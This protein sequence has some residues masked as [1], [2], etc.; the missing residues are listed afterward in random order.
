[1]AVL[2]NP[3]SPQHEAVSLAD[4]AASVRDWLLDQAP[5]IEAEKR[6]PD[7]VVQRLAS[8]DLFRMTQPS[9]F[10]GLGCSPRQAWEA[11]FQVAQGCGSCAWIIA[12]NAANVLMI[13][14]FSELAQQEV[15][16]SGRPAIISLLTG[17]VGIGVTADRVPGG[18]SLSGRWRYASGID[19]ASWAGLLVQLPAENGEPPE[20]CVMLVPKDS[21]SIDHSTW[22]VIGMRGTGSKDIYLK[23]TFVPE[24]RWLGW[25]QLQAGQK[26]PTCPNDETIYDYPLNSVFAMSILAPTL[27]VASAVAEEFRSV[28]KTRVSGVTQQRQ[29]DD[30][31]A[32]IAV[33]QGEATMAILRQTLLDD[34]DLVLDIIRSGRS[35]NPEERAAIRMRIAVSS[36]LAMDAAQ[37]MFSAMGGSLLPCNTRAE[38]LFRDFHAMSSHLLLQP[39]IIGEAYGRLLLGLEL[40]PGARL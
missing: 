36:R 19:I 26:H 23:P 11:V 20:S 7:D 33:A 24:H 2:S 37:R 16:E 17:G 28:V 9:R 4:K 8:A 13:G 34:A 38:R 40:P 3:V 35:P 15:F 12:L 5:R 25:K 21:F 29:C 1:M 10:G 6:I 31:L 32:Q 22:N 18:I 14:K 30:R 39:E 27:G